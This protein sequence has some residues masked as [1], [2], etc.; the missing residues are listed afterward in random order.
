MVNT[1]GTL[2][3]RN[4]MD[5][6]IQTFINSELMTTLRKRCLSEERLVLEE[7]HTEDTFKITISKNVNGKNISQTLELKEDAFGYLSSGI[8]EMF[9]RFYEREQQVSAYNV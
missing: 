2:G 8:N 5:N 4:F 1:F 3:K 9:K 7:S 6:K